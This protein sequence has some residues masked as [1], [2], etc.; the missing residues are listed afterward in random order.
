MRKTF[1]VFIAFIMLYVVVDQYDTWMSYNEI[2]QYYTDNYTFIYK[3]KTLSKSLTKQF[4]QQLKGQSHIHGSKDKDM[5]LH[6]F[7]DSESDDFGQIIIQIDKKTKTIY[8]FRVKSG[9]KEYIGTQIAYQR[10]YKI[11]HNDKEL[12]S[13]KDVNKVL[14]KMEDADNYMIEANDDLKVGGVVYT[15]HHPNIG[16]WVSFRYSKMRKEVIQRITPKRTK[17]VTD[18]GEYTNRD[19]F[20]KMTDELKKQ[21]EIAE[22]AEN[23][24]DDLAKIDQFIKKHSYKGIRDE[25]MLNIKD[26][27]NAVRKILDSYE[28]E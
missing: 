28:Q 10:G 14:D 21:S 9:S 17:I 26:H 16:V 23:I 12:S 20:Y 15:S 24:C 3:Q 19:H 6:Q 11:F 2:K 4:L 22:A 8:A 25:D 13:K 1:V 7:N 18:Y 5:V 27:M